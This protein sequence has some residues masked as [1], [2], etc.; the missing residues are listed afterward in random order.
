MMAAMDHRLLELLRALKSGS[1]VPN[2][3]FEPMLAY[4]KDNGFPAEVW[5]AV[6][7]GEIMTCK[8]VHP[9]DG[10]NCAGNVARRTARGAAS[11]LALYVPIHLIA[12]ILVHRREL[13]QASE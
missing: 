13:A 6:K 11:A 7:Q 8:A 9:A 1:V 10:T 3:P 2:D 5:T 12:Q 4:L